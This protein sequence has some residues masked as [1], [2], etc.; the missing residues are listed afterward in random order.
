MVFY[1][2]KSPWQPTQLDTV[3]PYS[4]NVGENIAQVEWEVLY[5]A[6]RVCAF[7]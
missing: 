1:E 5:S 4:V 2:Y 3:Q 6:F 7:S